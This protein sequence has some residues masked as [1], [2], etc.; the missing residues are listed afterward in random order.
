MENHKNLKKSL[1]SIR[2]EY[3]N[4]SNY[5]K[6]EKSKET[7]EN[8][9]NTYNPRHLKSLGNHRQSWQILWLGFTSY[10]TP[11]HKIGGISAMHFVL[12]ECISIRIYVPRK[13]FG[14]FCSVTFPTIFRNFPKIFYY[15][16]S[17]SESP[18][19]FCRKLFSNIDSDWNPF[20]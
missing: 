13:F 6:H 20:E 2:N 14:E 7:I 16:L 19:N 15:W 1:E 10:S 4:F 9:K 5:R 8:H 11:R 12:F 3:K 17:Y 18:S